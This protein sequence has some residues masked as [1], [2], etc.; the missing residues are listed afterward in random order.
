MCNKARKDAGIKMSKVV[1]TLVL[2]Y[3]SETWNMKLN[4]Y[5]ELKG[6]LLETKLV[7]KKSGWDGMKIHN[8]DDWNG[9]KT[10][11]GWVTVESLSS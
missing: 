8:K 6:A 1:A 4:F 10:L 3:D 2:I 7:M 9:Y 5:R 11:E